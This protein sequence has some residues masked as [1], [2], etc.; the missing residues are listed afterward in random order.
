MSRGSKT[1]GTGDIMPQMMVF[2]SGSRTTD[3]YIVEKV[4]LPVPRIGTMR[5]KATI[6]EILWVEWYLGIENL[7]DVTANSTQWGYLTTGTTRTTG[8][9]ATLDTLAEDVAD[10]KVVSIAIQTSKKATSGASVQTMP[11]VDDLTDRNGNGILVAADSLFIIKGATDQTTNA[12]AVA[13]VGFRLVNVG[14][15]EYVGIVQSQL[16]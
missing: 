5:N 2:D 7:E 12:R 13:R 9:A 15:T 11:I 16:G 3:D 8:L 10:P 1:G 4:A 6:Y 14:V